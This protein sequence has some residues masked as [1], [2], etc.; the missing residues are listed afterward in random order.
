MRPCCRR[1][2]YAVVRV[3]YNF[4]CNFV[5]SEP[6]MGTLIFLVM[7]YSG[8]CH[9]KHAENAASVHNTCLAAKILCYLQIIFNRNRNVK[10]QVSK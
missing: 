7:V 2:C 9:A 4:T 5:Y 3:H 1:Q 8:Q 10:Q 6:F